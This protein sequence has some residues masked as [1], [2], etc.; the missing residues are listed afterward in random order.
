[1]SL[2]YRIRFKYEPG[3]LC[4]SHFIYTYC[5]LFIH[6]INVWY[7]WNIHYNLSLSLLLL[8]NRG[9]ILHLSLSFSCL[10]QYDTK[11]RQNI[12]NSRINFQKI[13]P[14]WWKYNNFLGFKSIDGRIKNRWLVVNKIFRNRFDISNIRD[15][16][17]K[18]ISPYI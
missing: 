15:N 10:S 5:L 17:K 3:L 4:R 9:M 2:H 6:L 8:S 7:F 18:Y 1:M 12:H 16:L 14:V 11:F 13:F